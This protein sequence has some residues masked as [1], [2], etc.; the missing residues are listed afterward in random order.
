MRADEDDAV[1]GG[2]ALVPFHLVIGDWKLRAVGDHSF[3]VRDDGDIVVAFNLVGVGFEG[4]GF[5]ATGYPG[6][7]RL[8]EFLVPLA[9]FWV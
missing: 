2:V 9:Y 7:I 5:A 3:T 1:T 8:H 4:I 6:V